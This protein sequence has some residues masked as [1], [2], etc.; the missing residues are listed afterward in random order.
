[1]ANEKSIKSLAHRRDWIEMQ[2]LAVENWNLKH[3]VGIPVVVTRDNGDELHTKTRSH[4][5]LISGEIA[6]V[7]VDGISGFYMLSRVRPA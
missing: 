5:H 7:M 2:R 6:C 1:M 3:A 4:A